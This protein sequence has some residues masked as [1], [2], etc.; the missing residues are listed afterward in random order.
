MR[1]DRPTHHPAPPMLFL[2]TASIIFKNRCTAPSFLIVTL[3]GLLLVGC[4]DGETRRPPAALTG[5]AVTVDYPM[6]EADTTMCAG[7]LPERFA[8]A[9]PLP[10]VEGMP[11]RRAAASTEG[12]VRIPAGAFLMGAHYQEARPDEFPQHSVAVDGFWMDRTEVTNAQFR[13]FVE[14]TGYVTTAERDVDWE[15][16]KKQLPPST[17]RP[18]AEQLQASSLVFV[19]PERVVSMNHFAQWWQWVA[20]ADWQ[21]PEGPGSSIEGKDDYPVVQ[22]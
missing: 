18:P 17:P 10:P 19:A 22:V 14:A 7:D 21:H 2:L 15:E 1:R 4:T 13:A 8:A 6:P 20:G 3:G 9:P 5:A 16:M 11:V 12:M